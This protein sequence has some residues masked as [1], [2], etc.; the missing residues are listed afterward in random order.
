M[1]KF[2]RY[3]ILIKRKYMESRASESVRR[4]SREAY[5]VV[6]LALLFRCVGVV[7]WVEIGVK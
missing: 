1:T 3:V 7:G 5:V 4:C 6:V 2:K